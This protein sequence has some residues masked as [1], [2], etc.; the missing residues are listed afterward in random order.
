[1][2]EFLLG[3]SPAILI[4]I[5]LEIRSRFVSPG[6]IAKEACIIMI[7]L[8]VVEMIVFLYYLIIFILRHH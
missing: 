2:R 8:I 5:F 7:S 1:M 4:L 3:F 6:R